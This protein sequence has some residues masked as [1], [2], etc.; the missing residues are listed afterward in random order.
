MQ[1]DLIKRV[2]QDLGMSEDDVIKGVAAHLGVHENHVRLL[3][4]AVARDRAALKD[5]ELPYPLTPD[6]HAY[7]TKLS[8]VDTALEERTPPP[9]GLIEG[10]K[11]D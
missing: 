2:A 5:G 4:E 8:V 1:D 6:E 11:T 7:V 10:G 3:G 9:F